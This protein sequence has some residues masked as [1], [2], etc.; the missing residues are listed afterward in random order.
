MTFADSGMAMV[1]EPNGQMP[2]I[3]RSS[4]DFPEPE[5]PVTKICSCGA[6]LIPEPFCKG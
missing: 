3:A 6:M 1:P 5:G 4:V 2:D